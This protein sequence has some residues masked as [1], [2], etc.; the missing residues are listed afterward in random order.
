MKFP[1]S[2]LFLIILFSSCSKNSSTTTTTPPVY[3]PPV[4]VPDSVLTL[5]VNQNQPGYIIPANF[6]GFSYEMNQLSAAPTYLNAS[7][8]VLIQLMKN[9][10][11]GVI[12]FGGNSSD[13][14]TWTNGPR[15][16]ST[17]ANSLTT[18]EVDNISGFSKAL[19]WPVIFGL[20]MGIYDTAK[21]ASEATYVY[22][23]LQNNLMA[24][25]FGNEPDGY[26]SWNPVRASTY[27]ESNY[28]TD[29]NAYYTAVHNRVPAA[30]LAGPDVAYQSAWVASFAANEGKN[31]KFLS[32][33][34]Y[35]NGPSGSPGIN[36]SWLFT[37][38]PQYPNYFTVINGASNS[39]SLPWRI[40]ECNSIN[41][42]GQTGVSDVFAAALWGL[43]FMWNVAEAGGVGVNFHGGAG[44][45]YSPIV[46][47][48]NVTTPRPL[49]YAF[50]AFKY[51]ATG[52]TI[53][54]ASLGSIKYNV[55]AYAC[56][57]NGSPAITLINKETTQNII[58]NVQVSNK[59]ATIHIAR[60][61]AP[62]I[63][64]T[65]NIS[66]C[67]NTVNTSGLCTAGSTE[68]H[69]IGSS[70]SFSIALPA[71]SAAVVTMQ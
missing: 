37:T 16:G 24:L 55:S 19:G 39:S 36:I 21:A 60:L 50:L 45:A 59:Y 18:T 22:N 52:G 38:I 47:Y 34:Y 2:F 9:L 49:Y 46:Y 63:S 57:L 8:S 66:F 28:E 58:V 33:H 43:D 26:H 65:S 1:V 10:G 7:N 14:L 11:A 56:N 40:T 70:N 23:S 54:P 64:S 31:L 30:P 51:G 48:S 5:T 35:Q 41:G 4:V 20:D 44:G 68:D 42:G 29:W 27:S 53:I 13:A 12:R 69:S 71:A 15:T 32:S 62:A 6:Q 25:Q 17:P 3:I 67:N 61:S